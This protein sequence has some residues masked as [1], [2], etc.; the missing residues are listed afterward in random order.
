MF[1]SKLFSHPFFLF[2][3]D[4]GNGGGSGDN[5]STGEGGAGE[6]NTSQGGQA[7]QGQAGAQTQNLASQQTNAGGQ[8]T[9]TFTQADLDRIAGNTR[10]EAMAKFA[11]DHGFD[12]VE[13]LKAAIKAQKDAEEQAKSDLQKAQEA[14][15]RQKTAREAAE[16]ELHRLRI[17]T[18]ILEKA[19]GLNFANPRDAMALLDMSKVEIDDTGKVT[20]FEKQLDDLAKSGRLPLKGQQQGAG[21]GNQTRTRTSGAGGQTQNL[22]SQ[23]NQ[24]Q[25]GETQRPLVRL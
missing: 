1:R 23:Q 21:I 17:E 2:D 18:A 9:G 3:A 12:S 11:K 22:T 20:G 24:Q 6:G 14:E 25:G 8:Q 13:A 19:T 5:T 7:G 15:Q 16:A 10:K 4:T